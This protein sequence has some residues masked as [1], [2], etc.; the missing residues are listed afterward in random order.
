[1]NWSISIEDAVEALIGEELHSQTAEKALTNMS[2]GTCNKLYA[3]TS[4]C[5]SFAGT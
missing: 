3:P 1:M 4:G 5:A 2:Y